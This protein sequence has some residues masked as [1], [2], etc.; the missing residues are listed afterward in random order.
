MNS[1]STEYLAGLFFGRAYITPY[2]PT[3]DCDGITSRKIVKVSEDEVLQEKIFSDLWFNNKFTEDKKLCWD[4]YVSYRK[5]LIEKYI[6][7]ELF[8]HML[9]LNDELINSEDF[10]KGIRTAMW[11]CDYSYYKCMENSD[12]EFIREERPFIA[13]RRIIGKSINFDELNKKLEGTVRIEY[14]IKLTKGN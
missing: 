10:K 3:L 8:I 13:R 12:I 5:I 11:D 7:K 14:R 9:P 1:L 2:L 4:K 6:P